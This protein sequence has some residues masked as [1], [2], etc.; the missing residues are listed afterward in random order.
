MG[1]VTDWRPASLADLGA[2]AIPLSRRNFARLIVQLNS[3]PSATLLL[4]GRAVAIVTLAQTEKAQIEMALMCHREMSRL[5]GR[6][7]A[8]RQ[9]I[10]R[11]A[12][13]LP[14]ADAVMRISDHNRA[15]QK[16][17]RYA[18]FRPTNEVLTGTTVRTWIRPAVAPEK[19]TPETLPY[20][21]APLP[22]MENH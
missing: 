1:H 16:I 7:A 12:G 15:G 6:V 9:I 4:D 18:T 17:A 5:P 14:H 19:P 8:L 10:I 22:P 2:L 11:A 3:Y 13:M 21:S 20:A